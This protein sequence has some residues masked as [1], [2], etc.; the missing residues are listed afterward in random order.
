MVLKDADATAIYGAVVLNGVVLIGYKRGKGNRLESTFI[1]DG[2]TRTMDM[3]IH[4]MYRA[5]RRLVTM[6]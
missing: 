4:S 1:P 6:V 2:A 5:E 3:F